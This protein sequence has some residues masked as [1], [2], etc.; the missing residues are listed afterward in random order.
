MCHNADMSD[1][2]RTHELTL[3]HDAPASPLTFALLETPP[4]EPRIV[5]TLR[6]SG[7]GSLV[8]A[9]DEVPGS[10]LIECRDDHDGPCTTLRLTDGEVERALVAIRSA[11]WVK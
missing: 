7:G 4:H 5:A 9:D 1:S 10:V 11:H 3:A 6:L 2:E 8:I